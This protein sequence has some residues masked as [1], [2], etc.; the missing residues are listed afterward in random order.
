MNRFC[1]DGLCNQG[2]NC[3]AFFKDTEPM[4]PSDFANTEPADVPNSSMSMIRWSIWL[5]VGLGVL[6][7][8][9]GTFL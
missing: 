3:P 6:L 9:L 7:F 5:T 8:L 2:R 1:C 4:P